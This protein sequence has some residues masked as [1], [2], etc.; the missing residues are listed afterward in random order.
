MA[1]LSLFIP[2]K[3]KSEASILPDRSRSRLGGSL[4]DLSKA[5][6]L[7]GVLSGS[8]EGAETNFPDILNSRWM[9][10]RLLRTEYSF[11]IRTWRFG[12]W[13]PQKQTLFEYLNE[14]DMDRARDALQRIFT[15]EKLQRS[16]IL[17]LS[18]ETRSPELSQQIVE[19]S[20]KLLDL[21]LDHE[22]QSKGDIKARFASE[23]VQAAKQDFLS[24]EQ[25]LKAFANANRNYP[26]SSDPGVR[27]GGQRLEG[28]LKIRGDLL[29]LTMMNHENALME[30]ADDTATPNVLDH[31]NLPIRKSRPTRS[32]LVLM[33]AFLVG[34]ASLGWAQRA[35][36]ASFLREHDG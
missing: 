32:L 6:G 22:V 19:E 10:E 20:L 4:G 8:T 1:V 11:H 35:W 36:I 27:L 29:A 3:F 15:A 14:P 28:L 25:D 9:A 13:Q 31:G 16:P 30:A 34:A 7:S 17:V 5:A 12:A 33:A 21:F 24:A 18:I 23:R 26:V 2:D